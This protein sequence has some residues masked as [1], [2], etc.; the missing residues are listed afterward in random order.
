[1]SECLQLTDKNFQ[2]EVLDSELPVFVDFWGSWCPPCKMIEPLIAQLAEE[3]VGQVKVC[4]LNIDQNPAIRSLYSIS[5]APTFI[6]FDKGE[7]VSRAIGSKSKKQL[8]DMIET[9][10]S[11]TKVKQTVKFAGDIEVSESK[12]SEVLVKS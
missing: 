11:A 6:V 3:L 9:A 10:I 12:P 8:L 4:K 2:Q 1:M 7:V 5:A